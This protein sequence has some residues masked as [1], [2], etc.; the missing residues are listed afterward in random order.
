MD[1]SWLEEFALQWRHRL[2]AGRAPHA[3]MLSGPR[4][5]GKRAAAAWLAATRTRKA[6]P[7]SLPQYPHKVPE[8]PDIYWLT[9]LED[10]QSILIDQIRAFVADF[11][12]TSYEGH[13]KTAVIEPADRMNTAA[14]NSLLKTLEEPSGDALLVLVVDRMGKLPATIVSR[15]QRIDFKAPAEAEALAW[16]EA[17]RPGGDWV[18]P[19]AAA[20]GAPLEAVLMAERMD[21]Y[22]T[23]A[24]DLND[25]GSG[26][27]SPVDVAGRWSK[28]DVYGLLEWLARQVGE[29]AKQRICA[30]SR[31]PG[32]TI[33]KTVLARMDSRNLFCYLDIINRLRSRPEGSFNPQTALEGLLIDWASG[34]RAV[35]GAPTGLAG[36]YAASAG[37]TS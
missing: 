1:I 24:R 37:A 26:R 33:D 30:D 20:G 2:E 5:T 29:A 18:R 36:M 16:L 32:H 25:V 12:L 15:C 17:L 3:V 27:A 4:G 10:K 11:T 19:L 34:L 7:D 31:A 35:R 23:L 13:G 8:H 22:A 28:E 9:R 14:A 6:P 21:V